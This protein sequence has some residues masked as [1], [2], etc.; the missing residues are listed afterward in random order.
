M[1]NIKKEPQLP[2]NGQSESALDAM[3]EKSDTETHPRLS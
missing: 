3:N 1:T 2:V